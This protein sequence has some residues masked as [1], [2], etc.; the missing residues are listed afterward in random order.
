M[1]SK[2]KLCLITLGICSLAFLVACAA[3]S[4]S[5]ASSSKEKPS[6][7]KAQQGQTAS[8]EGQSEV[9]VAKLLAR[10]SGDM[11]VLKKIA[12]NYLW[13]DFNG[14]GAKDLAIVATLNAKVKFSV[15]PISA[16]VIGRAAF[17]PDYEE[18]EFEEEMLKDDTADIPLLVI[19]HSAGDASINNFQIKERFIVLDVIEQPMFLHKGKLDPAALLEAPQ[20]TPPPKLIGDAIVSMKEDY[21]GTAIFWYKGKYCGYPVEKKYPPQKQ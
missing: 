1:I 14:D 2:L 12:P 11:L 4:D 10:E 20:A 3:R 7:E 8:P 5:A 13:G 15:Q 18:Y 9:D 6:P 16:F 19:F 21:P 17:P